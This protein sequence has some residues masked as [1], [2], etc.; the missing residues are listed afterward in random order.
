MEV[1]HNALYRI[2]LTA[3]RTLQPFRTHRWPVH[4]SNL[5]RRPLLRAQYPQSHRNNSTSSAPG[6]SFKSTTS[7]ATPSDTSASLETKP[8]PSSIT[9]TPTTVP[10]Y[11]ITV[12]CRPC[13][14][15]SSHRISHQGYHRGTVLITCPS[16]KNRHVISDHLKIFS[17]TRVTIE[18]I[19]RNKGEIIRK[20]ALTGGSNGEALEFW[21]EDAKASLE[22]GVQGVQEKETAPI[23]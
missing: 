9:F 3:L 23:S 2:G 21:D 10:S 22:S 16:C 14:H 17:D 5:L 13:L 1:S 12:T 18:D 19:L 8:G 20:G 6:A 15:R 11:A 4:Q 7:S